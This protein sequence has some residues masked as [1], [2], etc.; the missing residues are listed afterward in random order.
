MAKELQVKVFGKAGCDKCKVLNERLDKLLKK[1]EWEDFEKA[2]CDVTTEDGLVAFCEI[3]CAN[4]QR[5]PAFVVH[6]KTGNNGDYA[7]L[8][9]PAPGKQDKVCKGARLYQ[10]LGL[11]TDYSAAGKGIISPKMISAVLAEAKAI[12]A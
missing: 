2:Y 5:I 10:Y 4:P 6:R 9:N 11:Q 1:D 7:P 12:S 3:E 8:V